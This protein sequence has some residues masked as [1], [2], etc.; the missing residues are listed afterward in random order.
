MDDAPPPPYSLQDP[1]APTSA[2]PFYPP[3]VVTAFN[4]FVGTPPHV[5][6]LPVRQP[7]GQSGA[8]TRSAPSRSPGSP[9]LATPLSLTPQPRPSGITNEELRNIGFVSAAPYFELRTPVQ[10]RPNTV[11]YHHISVSPGVGPDNVPFPQPSERWTSR[12]V[13]DQDWMTF[14]NHL[15]PPH[16]IGRASCRERV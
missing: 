9:G 15:F 6:G 3:R 11:V 1:H 16:E 13:D 10:P 5:P 8:P 4:A 7:S 14:L 12:E 2:Q